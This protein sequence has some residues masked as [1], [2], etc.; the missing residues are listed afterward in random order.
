MSWQ[1]LNLDFTGVVF[2][3]GSFSG[4]TVSFADAVFSGGQVDFADA[5]FSGGTVRFDRARFSGGTVGFHYAV[6]SGGTVDFGG[7]YAARF[8]AAKSTSAALATGQPHPHSP[9]HT[10]RRQA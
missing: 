9:G 7:T 2:D 6:F 3:G 4:G 8:P 1:G 10:R 5:V